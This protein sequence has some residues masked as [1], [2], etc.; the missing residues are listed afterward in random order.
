[1]SESPTPVLKKP[2]KPRRL[3]YGL[4]VVVCL[5]WFLWPAAAFANDPPAGGQDDPSWWELIYQN[6]LQWFVDWFTGVSLDV[7]EVVLPWVLDLLPDH[8]VA[9]TEVVVGLL[10]AVDAFIPVA[11]LLGGI[12]S[13]FA[14]I[15]AFITVKIFLKLC[16]WIG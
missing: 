5:A 10:K 14:F 3:G 6:T 13:Y 7:G 1:M 12:G 9:G 4:A 11:V 8:P 2:R 16:P 15:T